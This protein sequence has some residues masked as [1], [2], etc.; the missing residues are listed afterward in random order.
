MSVGH[1]RCASANIIVSIIV[2]DSQLMRSATA[3]SDGHSHNHGHAHGGIPC[4]SNHKDADVRSNSP[5]PAA[6]RHGGH[7]HGS[8]QVSEEPEGECSVVG[9]GVSRSSAILNLA[10]DATHNFTDGLA[11]GGAHS[12]H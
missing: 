6:A 5:S 10:A 3:P 4:N 8:V 2:F 9:T 12:R 11:I 7:G 1:L